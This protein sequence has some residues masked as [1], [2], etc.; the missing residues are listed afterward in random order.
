ML[1]KPTLFLCSQR[2]VAHTNKHPAPNKFRQF[3]TPQVFDVLRNR[4][5]ND[6]LVA[7]LAQ[8]LSNCHL[9]PSTVIGGSHAFVTEVLPALRLI[10]PHGRC[11]HQD[12]VVFLIACDVSYNPSFPF[13]QW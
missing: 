12:E 4:R 8:R 9:G 6:V 13:F 10:H 1:K 2:A 11:R 5:Q 7:G 3:S